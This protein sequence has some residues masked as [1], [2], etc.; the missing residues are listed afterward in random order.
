MPID[1]EVPGIDAWVEVNGRKAEV[2][3]D[4]DVSARELDEEPAKHQIFKYIESADD[5]VF[6][7]QVDIRGQVIRNAPPPCNTVIGELY[8]DGEYIAGR[9]SPVRLGPVVPD[10]FRFE[11]KRVNSRSRPGYVRLLKLVFSSVSTVDDTDAARIAKD[12]KT[13][14]HLGLIQL[15]FFAGVDVGDASDRRFD[16]RA[17]RTLSELAE[18]SL[19]GKAISHG[20]S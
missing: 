13:A 1:H 19:K 8:V 10:R 17:S 7:V 16:S 9:C 11:A 12:L 20:T 18:K 6:T 4:H 5:A 2:F 3:D 15:R 14:K